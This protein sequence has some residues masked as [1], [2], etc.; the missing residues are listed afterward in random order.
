MSALNNYHNHIKPLNS[1]HIPNCACGL[2]SYQLSVPI[3][4]YSTASFKQHLIQN[5]TG[6]PLEKCK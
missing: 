5:I 3:N 6:L 1:V 4:N 2:D